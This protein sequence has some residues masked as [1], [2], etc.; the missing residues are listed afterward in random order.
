MGALMEMVLE[1][2]HDRPNAPPTHPL[3]PVIP[4]NACTPRFPPQGA[5]GIS[6]SF[7]GLSPTKRQIPTLSAVIARLPAQPY[8]FAP[9]GDNANTATPPSAP[10]PIATPAA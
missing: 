3:R 8:D 6:P 5:C 2:F 4:I 10:T 9:Y 1:G 7:P